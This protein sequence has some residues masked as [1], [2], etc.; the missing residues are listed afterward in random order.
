M[1][2]Y[3]DKPYT[4]L[5]CDHYTDKCKSYPRTDGTTYTPVTRVTRSEFDN[6]KQE[7]QEL[8]KLLIRTKKYDEETGQPDCEAL[9]NIAKI[10]GDKLPI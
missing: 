2:I 8:K 5:I 9:R 3:D 10:V 6:L 7:V 1:S 4:I